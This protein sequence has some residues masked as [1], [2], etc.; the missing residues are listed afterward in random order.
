M[1]LE[2]QLWHLISLLLSFFGFVVGTAK[3]LLAQT[4]KRQNDKDIA[5]DSRWQETQRHMDT[6]LL[7]I[8]AALKE[9]NG[10]WTRLERELLKLK[11]ELP[12]E[13]V[14][15]EDYV[16]GQA[17][18]EAKLDALYSKLETLLIKGATHA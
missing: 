11:A 13:Y 10:E 14:R 18:L 6:R 17:V 8:E 3:Y 4:E 12:V 2:L 15:R 5:Q 1:I 9:V 16:R 7:A